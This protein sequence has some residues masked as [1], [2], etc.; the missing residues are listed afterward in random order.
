[1]HCKNLIKFTDKSCIEEYTENNIETM[2]ILK[3]ISL[4]KT[5]ETKLKRL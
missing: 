4:L 3:H 1:M 5:Y 2:T